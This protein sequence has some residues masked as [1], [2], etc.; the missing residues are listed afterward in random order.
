MCQHCAPGASQGS[1]DRAQVLHL[2][3]M[4]EHP[5]ALPAEAALRIA[6]ALL[7]WTGPSKSALGCERV[8]APGTPISND[9]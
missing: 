9:A 6:G 1:T 2:L 7:A 5:D 3:A 4:L 8:A